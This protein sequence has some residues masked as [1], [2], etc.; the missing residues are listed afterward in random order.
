L[1]KTVGDVRL[2]F[3]NTELQIDQATQISDILI[4]LS[5]IF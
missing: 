4:K 2:P 5:L 1:K 3:P